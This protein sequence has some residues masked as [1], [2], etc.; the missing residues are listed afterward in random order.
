M[1]HEAEPRQ[2]GNQRAN[3]TAKRSESPAS[4][5]VVVMTPAAVHRNQPSSCQID[6]A[7]V[8]LHL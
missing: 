6:A 1:E 2:P 8:A 3:A 5:L 4:F 7:I